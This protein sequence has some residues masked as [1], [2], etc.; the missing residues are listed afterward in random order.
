[1]LD[2]GHALQHF[3]RLLRV[4]LIRDAH[5]H[6]EASEQIA[7]R[8]V[9][10]RLRD[11][12]GVGHDKAG[13]PECFD[14][15]RP[16]GD[17]AHVALAL[18][19]GDPVA[20]LDRTLDQQDQSRDEIVDD[21]LQA[22]TDADR[23]RA[24]DDGEAGDVEAGIGDGGERGDGKADVAG[25]GIDR[26]GEAGVHTPLRQC[27]R[28]K[29]PLHEARRD[30]QAAQIAPPRP[31]CVPAKRAPRRHRSRIRRPAPSS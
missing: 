16:H 13:A 24:R 12:L 9:D 28:G 26:V 14:L 22:E 23:Q 8:E 19:D 18:L 29:P 2:S 17:A 15:G 4:G 25:T 3:H 27:P 31:G 20:D 11:Q 21:R 5:L 10:H 6:L 7:V 30:E 1:M